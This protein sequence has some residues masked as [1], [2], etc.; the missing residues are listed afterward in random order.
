MLRVRAGWTFR[1]FRVPRSCLGR[2]SDSGLVLLWR[3][4]WASRRLQEWLAALP[5]SVCS[6]NSG[7]HA[8]VVSAPGSGVF[9]LCGLIAAF[10]LASAGGSLT[11][12]PSFA[13]FGAV[14]LDW[15]SRIAGRVWFSNPVI[16]VPFSECKA[17]VSTGGDSAYPDLANPVG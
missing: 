1:S 14:P 17:M 10:L 6:V 2:C 7:L 8:L 5:G 3:P 13:S 16:L 9:L 15:V 12:G 4:V 11:G